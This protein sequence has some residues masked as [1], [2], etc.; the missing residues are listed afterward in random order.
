MFLGRGCSWT[1]RPSVPAGTARRPRKSP[2]RRTRS[3]APWDALKRILH[4]RP[5]RHYY[6]FLTIESCRLSGRLTSAGM[7]HCC[8]NLLP[9][10]VPSSDRV[11]A[12]ILAYSTSSNIKTTTISSLQSLSL[13]RQFSLSLSFAFAFARF[14]LQFS[15]LFCFSFSF[16]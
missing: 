3:Q 10:G 9:T 13:S 6:P 14:L 11:A 7:F 4:P 15:W 5:E 12:I 1:K 2:S 8:R 16:L